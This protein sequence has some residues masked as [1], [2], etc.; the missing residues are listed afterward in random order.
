MGFP[1]TAWDLQ[2]MQDGRSDRPLDLQAKDGIRPVCTG[3]KDELLAR[4]WKE[5]NKYPAASGAFARHLRI[6]VS[7]KGIGTYCMKLNDLSPLKRFMPSRE[8]VHRESITV[9]S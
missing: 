4:I 3:R 2:D 5:P 1:E 9:T 7:V 6:G 8:P